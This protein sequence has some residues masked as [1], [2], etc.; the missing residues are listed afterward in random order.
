MCRC[1]WI[2]GMGLATRELFEHAV[3][4]HP[5]GPSTRR[6]KS[7]SPQSTAC[8][9]TKHH[10]AGPSWKVDLDQLL[11][12]LVRTLPK[13]DGLSGATRPTNEAPIVLAVGRFGRRK[14]ERCPTVLCQSQGVERQNAKDEVAARPSRSA[15][16]EVRNSKVPRNLPDRSPRSTAQKMGRSVRVGLHHN[17]ETN[18]TNGSKPNQR[19]LSQACVSA[20]V[21]QRYV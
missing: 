19:S 15:R 8:L 21:V 9:R 17:G 11:G 5:Q 3:G 1:V 14:L 12:D 2:L 16:L 10:V 13:R 7:A 20:N 6:K 4:T 18:Q